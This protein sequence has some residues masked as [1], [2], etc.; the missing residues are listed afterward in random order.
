MPANSAHDVNG[1]L[2]VTGNLFVGGHTFATT[3]LLA[4][5]TAAAG[6]NAGTSPPT[7]VV[8]ATATDARGTLTFGS[9]S[10]TPAIGAQVVVTFNKVLPK[11]PFVYLQENN[12]ATK[13]LHCYV[14]AQSTTGFT[15]STLVAPG[16]S[17]ANTVYSVQWRI[18]L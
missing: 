2:T 9:G 14:S 18:E 11:T 3:D 8:A 17:Q 6:A 13:T 15:I 4:A 10:G 12:S 16:V 7:P 5:P 1:D